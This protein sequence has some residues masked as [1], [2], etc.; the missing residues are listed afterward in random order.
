MTKHLAV[1]KPPFLDLILTGKKN[2]ESRFSRVRCAPYE[3]VES[4]DIVLLKKSGGLIYG[5]FTV[6]KVETFSDM[7]PKML[8]TLK[9][10][11]QAICADADPNFWKTRKNCRYV[12]LIHIQKPKRYKKPYSIT[13]H[14]RRGWVVL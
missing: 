13:K 6:L 1:F 2:I 5:E 8:K 4:G 14:D 3:K 10:Y 12:T 11:S 7:T 9:K